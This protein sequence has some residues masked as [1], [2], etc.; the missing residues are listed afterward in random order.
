ML[1]AKDLSRDYLKKLSDLIPRR[2][3]KVT[4]LKGDAA[5]Y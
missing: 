3:Q 5:S 2:I 1:W 4:D